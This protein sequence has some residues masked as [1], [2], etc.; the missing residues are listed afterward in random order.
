[1]TTSDPTILAAGDVSEHRG[2][3]YGI[4]P[5]AYAQ[6]VV[7]GA[8]AVRGE[9]TFRGIPPSN[10]LKVLDIEMFSIGQFQPLDASYEVLEREAGG[11]Y[12]RLVLHDGRLAGA[13]LLGNTGA[14][15]IVRL[16]I[17]SG[18][19]VSRLPELAREFPW[20]AAALGGRARTAHPAAAP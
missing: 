7:A 5:A 15:G 8:V 11:V 4:W 17:E 10:R 19:Q 18:A 20:A 13:N 1:M 16:A 14:S 2:V 12:A 3:C 9:A 6:G